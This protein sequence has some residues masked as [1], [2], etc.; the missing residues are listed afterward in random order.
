M[1]E[2]K[3]LIGD[4]TAPQSSGRKLI[5]HICNDI[6]EWGKGFVLAVSRRWPEAEKAYREWHRARETNDFALGSVQFVQ[7][8]PDIWVANMIGQRGI[9]STSE[10]P[11][12]RYE[13]VE[14]CLGRVA[15]K[16]LELGAT[17]HMPRIGCGLAGG[18]WDK[19]GPIVIDQLCNRGVSV[20][21]YDL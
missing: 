14:R 20:C 15:T 17:T 5:V 13:A 1:G 9:R 2:I 11:P 21:V 12:I 10:E 19:I 7:V 8:T 16:A 18:S 6:G 3:Y 4:A